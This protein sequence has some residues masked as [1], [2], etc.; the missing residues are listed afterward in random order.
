MIIFSTWAADS[1]LAVRL[2]TSIEE[3]FGKQ[4]IPAKVFQSP[5]IAQ[6]A[7]ILRQ[8][9][10]PDSWS[11][12]I[13]VQPSGSQPPF[14][15]VHGD[16]SNSFLPRYLGWD[17]P[18][19]GLEHQSQDGK[20]ALYDSVESIASHYLD[21]IHTVQ[22]KGPYFLGG[23]SFGAMVAFEMAQQLKKAGA[24]VALLALLD[25]PSVTSSKSSSSVVPSSS[26]D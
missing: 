4:L 15:W 1:L 3:V 13:P 10:Q 11:S 18:L 12:L 19:Y 24:D 22:P 9:K 14:F 6:L 5:T 17:Q 16:L 20:P 23:Y 7:T 21:E 25:P 26:N 8:E 2:I